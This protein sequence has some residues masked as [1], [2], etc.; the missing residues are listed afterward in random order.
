MRKTLI[1]L[2]VMALLP[3]F[4]FAT[5]QSEGTG[6]PTGKMELKYWSLFGGSDGGGLSLLGRKAFSC[7]GIRTWHVSQNVRDRWD[8]RFFLFLCLHLGFGHRRRRRRRRGRGPFER[9]RSNRLHFLGIAFP[10][11]QRGELSRLRTNRAERRLC[12]EH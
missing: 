4:V 10:F 1:V 7:A 8:R 6:Q 12:V 3:V 9:C 11:D 2:F 5:G